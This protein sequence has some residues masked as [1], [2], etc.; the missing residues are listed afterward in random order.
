MGMYLAGKA[1][2][3][4]RRISKAYTFSS[5]FR[6]GDY[7]YKGVVF[8]EEMELSASTI[9]SINIRSGQTSNS[10]GAQLTVTSIGNDGSGH[11][12]IYFTYYAPAATNS[13]ITYTF[14]LWYYDY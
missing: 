1:E 7:G 12:R 4:L 8:D 10:N 14:D 11:P 9:A 2:K 6:A 3:K 13:A 5:A